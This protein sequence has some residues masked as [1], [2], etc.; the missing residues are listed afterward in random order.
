MIKVEIN[1][2]I[3]RDIERRNCWIQNGSFF[4]IGLERDRCKMK[5]GKERNTNEERHID[6]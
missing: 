2:M 1:R 5:D 6:K 4:L 3:E